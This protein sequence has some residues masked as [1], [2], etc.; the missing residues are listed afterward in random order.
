M[1]QVKHYDIACAAD[2]RYA[3]L[4]AVMLKSAELS[5]S[6]NTRF[7]VWFL[8]NGL[9]AGRKSMIIDSLDPDKMAIRFLK[10]SARD[11]SMLTPIPSGKKLTAYH[12]LF[13]PG[14]LG[15]S[16]RRLVYL[17]C[18]TIVLDDLGPLFETPLA[19]D[20]VVAAARDANAWTVGCDWG[21]GVPNWDSLGMQK[22]DPYFNSGVL[23]IDIEKWNALEITQRVI[24]C[25]AANLNH[26]VWLD[27]YGLNV[28]LAQKWRELP[29]VWN[30]Y[31]EKDVE[32]PKI[33]HFVSRKP[34]QID[35]NGRYQD[36]FFNILDQTHWRSRRPPKIPLIDWFPR[37]IAGRV[38]WAL[39]PW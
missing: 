37:K 34:H 14:I 35:Y 39:S 21:G 8:D 22:E 9:T 16:V 38:K 19:A 3:V 33:I 2:N 4:A 18:D 30:A 17:D 27:Q 6:A 11:W 20:E 1:K 13:I 10:P 36:L 12:R 25:T 29:E 32:S 23:L 28:V 31:P 5:S 15:N 24:E 7:R 26:V